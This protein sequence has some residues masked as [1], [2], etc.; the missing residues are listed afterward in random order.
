MYISIF[1]PL[2]ENISLYRLSR[3]LYLIFYCWY[4]KLLDSLSL[5]IIN[6]IT[7]FCGTK[8]RLNFI[9]FYW[10]VRDSWDQSHREVLASYNALVKEYTFNLSV[11]V[12]EICDSIPESYRLWGSS[13]LL[14]LT[15]ISCSAFQVYTTLFSCLPIQS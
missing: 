5:N 12:G 8:G 6:C 4:K 10:R 13:L 15:S 3:L 2:N 1:H 9:G 14:T 7:C 11:F